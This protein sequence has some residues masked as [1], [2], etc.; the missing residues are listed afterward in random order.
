MLYL[1]ILIE[2]ATGN[3]PWRRLKDKEQIGQMKIK[4][5]TPDLVSDLP[6]EFLQFMQH[7]Q[8][9]DYGDRP[10]YDYL[11]SLLKSRFTRLGGT[12]ESLYDWQQG[13]SASSFHSTQLE[14]HSQL[15]A[16]RPESQPSPRHRIEDGGGEEDD[17]PDE[18]RGPSHSD[19]DDADP[20]Q[21]SE[22]G[23]AEVG[24][25][26]NRPSG[27]GLPS[28]TSRKPTDSGAHNAA[29]DRDHSRPYSTNTAAPIKA[30]DTKGGN[31]SHDGGVSGTAGGSGA[32]VYKLVANKK[33][34]TSNAA[35]PAAVAAPSRPYLE[36]VS[37]DRAEQD[38]D[39]RD[40][41]DEPLEDEDDA[42]DSGAPA[43][44]AVKMKALRRSVDDDSED[45]VDD[46]E[47]ADGKRRSPQSQRPAKHRVD[48][49]DESLKSQRLD[50]SISGASDSQEKPKV[51][52]AHKVTQKEESSCCAG[53]SI[54]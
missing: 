3:L 28:N 9:L 12:D 33:L 7:L 43:N 32:P 16:S 11:V 40:D 47:K 22:S 8:A 13:N 30:T 41:D 36:D 19:V 46:S 4:T 23:G 53:C 17:G 34:V 18:N 25:K 14:Q 37:D 31:T 45:D 27:F 54:M 10:D 26:P 50:D 44:G 52:R 51:N 5:N 24:K 2:F 1:D 49:D 35:A 39:E 15:K 38:S 20:N 21:L 42:D 29:M 48:P 6:P